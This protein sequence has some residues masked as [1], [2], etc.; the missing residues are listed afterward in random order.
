MS[1]F[2]FKRALTLAATLLCA[3][4]V[5]FFVLEVLPGDAALVRLGDTATP[6]A[7]AALRRKLCPG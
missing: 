3:S 2:L 5:I 4:A 6:E 1:W 7:V